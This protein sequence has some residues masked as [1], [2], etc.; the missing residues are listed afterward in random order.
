[1]EQKLSFDTVPIY[2]Y[3]SFRFFEEHEKHMTRVVSKDVLVLVFSGTL[4]FLEN[5]VPISVSA[6][7]YYI[8]RKG[9]YHTAA[10]ESDMPKYYFIHFDG[11]FSDDENGLPLR[12]RAD[13]SD[14]FLLFK[15]LDA[16][17]MSRA[18]PLERTAAFLEILSVLKKQNDK[19]GK[20]DVVLKV[21]TMV[22]EDIQQPFSLDDVAKKCGYSKNHVINVFKKETGK[23]PYAYITD[24]RID[25]AKRLLLNSES[26]LVQ[27][28][29]ECGYGDY[30]NFYKAFIKAVG[31]APLAW[32]RRKLKG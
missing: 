15:K 31:E 8:Q 7:E 17:Q 18:T 1:M 5:G 29:M 2:N 3:A 20:S 25:M 24:I 22:S 26:S 9:S 11:D 14:L 10:E 6:G 23:T 13:F 27:I 21:I 12:G 4:K 28:G 32:K 16:L 19:S 30:I